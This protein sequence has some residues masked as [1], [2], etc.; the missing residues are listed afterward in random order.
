[1][2]NNKLN[3]IKAF[4]KK[5]LNQHM[6][7]KYATFSW[8]NLKS[9]INTIIKMTYLQ[10]WNGFRLHIQAEYIHQHELSAMIKQI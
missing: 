2:R 9:Q 1:M 6:N 5:Y 7:H 3:W 8:H 10:W 4:K